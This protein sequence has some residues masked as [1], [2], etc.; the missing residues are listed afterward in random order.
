MLP[1]GFV[2]LSEAC[3]TMI[4]GANYATTENFTGGVVDGY[5]KREAIFSKLGAEAL[6]RVH[7]EARA[8]GLNVKVFDSYRPVRAVTFFQAWARLP[9]GNP[10][11]KARYY[12]HFTRQE[13]FEHGYIAQR[14]SHS[15]GSAVDL[16]L[17]KA[18][19]TELDMGTIFDFFHERSHTAHRGITREQRRNRELL[20]G[21]MERH[22]FKNFAQEWWHYSLVQ[23]AFPGQSFDFDVD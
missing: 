9:E 8:Q 10:E 6:C 14:S 20:K 21:M 5:R 23:E 2:R 18:D 17:T 16:T 3:P 15:R 1:Q 7:A 4:I 13:L 11:I 19:G 22:G 12:P